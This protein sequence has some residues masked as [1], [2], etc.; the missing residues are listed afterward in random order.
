VDAQNLAYVIQ[1][2][3]SAGVMIQHRGVVNRL[4]WAQRS[5]GLGP[6]DRCLLS[7]EPWWPL[8]A[9]ARLVV[10]PPGAG[11]DAES[12]RTV[13]HDEGITTAHLPPS[14]LRPALRHGLGECRRL[15]RVFSGGE[16]L[17]PS[18]RDEFRTE[19]PATLH[20]GYGPAETTGE[21]SS[22][23]CAP[24]EESGSVPIGH[25]IANV[26]IYVLDPHLRPVPVGVSGDVYIGGDALARGY[27]GR[28]A[29][30]AERFV[31][32]PFGGQAGARLYRTGD[33]G[34]HRADGALE[35]T[36]R[37][38][39]AADSESES[40]R[41]TPR[42]A[43]D[44]EGRVADAWAAVLG[45]AEVGL[46]DNFFDL[47]GHSMLLIEVRGRLRDEFGVALSLVDL[48]S[49]PTVS[50]LAAYIRSSTDGQRPAE[51]AEAR[52]GRRQ[53]AAERSRRLRAASAEARKR[54]E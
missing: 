14:V 18:L 38:A 41:T 50:A 4:W 44:L 13:I 36:G 12:L 32:S 46:Q 43:D 39:V 2:P 45:V 49:Y 28:P 52:T 24:G 7:P 5:F 15:R 1:V 33:V 34:R 8:I 26:Q 22:W 3:E 23:T 19:L 37:P 9:G 53:A 29:L 51:G 47:G 54:G 48:Y 40:A 10:A 31:P 17:P 11:S 35:L 6:D 27:L 25:P 42:S 21:A 20:H 30:T 16:A